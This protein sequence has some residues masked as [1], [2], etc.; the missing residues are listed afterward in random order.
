M[1]NL[2][3]YKRSYMETRRLFDELRIYSDYSFKRKLYDFYNHVTQDEYMKPHFSELQKGFEKFNEK[4][5]QK[6]NRGEIF[7]PEDVKDR[8]L[9]VVGMMNDVASGGNAISTLRMK[10]GGKSL[11][12]VYGK[13]YDDIATYEM[14]RI[15]SNIAFEIESIEN[16]QENRNKNDE[17]IKLQPQNI[18]NFYGGNHNT[19]IG[20]SNI[21][22]ITSE[23]VIGE[24]T[25]FDM[26]NNEDNRSIVT[27]NIK[28][29]QEEIEK[30]NPSEERIKGFLKKVIDTGEDKVIRW[31]LNQFGRIP[32]FLNAVS[33]LL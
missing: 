10:Y 5:N 17:D 18:N 31:S 26:F 6:M 20:D 22:N 1:N 28:N 27:E 13:W 19:Q 16:K 29:I 12:E 4:Y 14:N 2:L 32:E 7:L 11:R 30:D 3:E 8:I 24:L 33:N 23:N 9:A 21:Q 15:F 25:Q